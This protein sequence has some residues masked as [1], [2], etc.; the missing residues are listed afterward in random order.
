MQ[1]EPTNTNVVTDD[2]LDGVTGGCLVII[3]PDPTSPPKN[4]DLPVTIQPFPRMP[5]LPLRPILFPWKRP[6]FSID[7]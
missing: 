6:T 3:P 7:V 5:S 1:T 2:A 4:P